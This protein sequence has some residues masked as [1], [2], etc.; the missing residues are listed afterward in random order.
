VDQDAYFPVGNSPPLKV[1]RRLLFPLFRKSF[2]NQIIDESK[3]FQFHFCL[4]FKGD[5]V[6]PQTIL[7]LK[8]RGIYLMLFYPDVSLYAHGPRIPKCLPLYDHIFTTKSYGLQDMSGD[9]ELSRIELLHH[10]FDPDAY[11]PFELNPKS[12]KLMGCDV[13]FIGTWSPKKEQYL[14]AIAERLP[15]ID[16]RIWGNQWNKSTSAILRTIIVG[17]PL[18]GD[19][20]ASA[21]QANAINIALL[22]ERRPGASLGDQ[23]TSRSFNIPSCGGFMIHERTDEVLEFY[24]EGKEI[25]CF[26][27][28]DEL[29]EKIT[30]YLDHPNERESI[31]LAGHART[32]AE[33][34]IENRAKIIIDHYFGR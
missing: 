11:R 13:S 29:A 27:N 21:V 25:A 8:N 16:M 33:N 9:V 5:H 10:G 12:R 20:Y 6:D 18:I 32:I 17:M 7:D 34:N 4:A 30:Y 1:A 28:P 3:I 19:F 26:S 2:N 14:R 31:R 15:G 23:V 24:E 22:S